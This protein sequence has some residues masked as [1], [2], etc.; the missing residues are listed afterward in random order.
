MEKDSRT[1]NSTRDLPMEMKIDSSQPEKAE[2]ES[3]TWRVLDW[4]PSDKR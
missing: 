4:N 3:I 1:T 2:R